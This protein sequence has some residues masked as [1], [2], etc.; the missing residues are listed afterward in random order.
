MKDIQQCHKD[1]HPSSKTEY[2]SNATKEQKIHNHQLY[3]AQNW[4]HKLL[5]SIIHKYTDK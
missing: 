5:H 1:M 2:P 3:N 4:T